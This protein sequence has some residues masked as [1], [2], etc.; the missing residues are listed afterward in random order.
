[1]FFSL[2]SGQQAETIDIRTCDQAV[3]KAYPDKGNSHLIDDFIIVFIKM[4]LLA[5]WVLIHSHFFCYLLL[6]D[7]DGNDYTTHHSHSGSADVGRTVEEGRWSAIYWEKW[8]FK[9][10]IISYETHIDF[11]SFVL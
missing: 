2:L 11:F 8:I 1:M 6:T 9:C 10:F 7:D 5:G 3:P 4:A